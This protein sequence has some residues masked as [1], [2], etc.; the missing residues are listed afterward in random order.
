M[1][2]SEFDNDNP[3]P[4]GFTENSGTAFLPDIDHLTK[5]A[6]E[7]F[8]ALPCD[9]SRPGIAA[10]LVTRGLTS[11]LAGLDKAGVTGITPQGFGLL[12]GAELRQLFA[13][14]Q[15]SFES[16]PDTLD[17]GSV[18]G[19]LSSA[20]FA[21]PLSGL[22]KSVLAVFFRMTLDCLK[23]LNCK[24]CWFQAHLPGAIFSEV[25]NPV[26]FLPFRL[27]GRQTNCLLN[28]WQKAAK[29]RKRVFYLRVLRQN[30]RIFS[31]Q[32]LRLPRVFDLWDGGT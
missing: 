11:S 4:Q 23:R 24:K 18:F 15:P 5:L 13:P 31:L 19:N 30:C 32:V 12:R 27:R 8:S 21:S 6:N 3:A 26:Q 9:G 16:V 25:L 10:S 20:G 28:H 1:N 7:L 2:T 14:R 17:T 22:D 29:Q